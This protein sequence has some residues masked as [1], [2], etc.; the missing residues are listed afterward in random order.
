MKT[1]FLISEGDVTHA[2]YDDAKGDGVTSIYVLAYDEEDA[3]RCAVAYDDGRAQPDN[4]NYCGEVIGA[5]DS[6]CV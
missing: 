6:D 4:C 3:V 2:D 5:I 1:L